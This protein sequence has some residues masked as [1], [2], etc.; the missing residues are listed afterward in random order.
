M[1]GKIISINGN[2]LKVELAIDVTNKTGL[3]NLHVAI[4]CQGKKLIGEIIEIDLKYATISLLGEIINN[5]FISGVNTKPSFASTIRIITKDE[6]NQIID[7]ENSNYAI[8]FGR[9]P[10]YSNYP[11]NLNP[12]IFFSNHS[13][14]VGNS[15][16][17]KSSAVARLFQNIFSTN[18]II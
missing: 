2:I 4:E 18:N 6:L 12:D 9:L 15:G 5:Q 14:I 13:A 17:G 11:I 8:N 3:S 16:S 10:L 7:F 1:L